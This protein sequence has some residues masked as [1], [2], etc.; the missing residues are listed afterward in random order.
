MKYYISSRS[1]NIL[2]D[3]D[4]NFRC[5]PSRIKFNKISAFILVIGVG[6]FIVYFL[7]LH[8]TRLEPTIV[9]INNNAS[10]KQATTHMYS[11]LSHDIFAPNYVIKVDEKV[12]KPASCLIIIRT[13]DGGKGNRMFL[14]ASAYGLARLHQC[15]LYVGPWILEDLRTIFHINI[16]NTPVNLVTD[17]TV[18][19]K[20]GL[21][22]RYSSC[23][24]FDDLLKIPLNSNLTRY[25]MIGFYQA[26]GYFIKYKDE[27]SYLFQFN[28]VAV[29][30]NIP[31]VEQLLKGLIISH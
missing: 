19:K 31:L 25:E 26:F 5:C 10:L 29:R 2:R 11:Y 8:Q 7:S 1:R 30:N 24:L 17:D 14:F 3:T 23:T 6:L 9:Y 21:Y 27:I 20:P 13:A 18:V 16:S 15:E 12:Q 4:D 28:Q 22:G